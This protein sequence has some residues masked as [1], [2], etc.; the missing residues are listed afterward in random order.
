[1]AVKSVGPLQAV[2]DRRPEIALAS[3]S[4]LLGRYTEAEQVGP[5]RFALCLFPCR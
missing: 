3:L 2:K 5:G 1:M 4:K